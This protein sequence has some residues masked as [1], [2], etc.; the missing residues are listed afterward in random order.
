MQAPDKPKRTLQIVP[1]V[2]VERE[3]RELIESHEGEYKY[4]YPSLDDPLFNTK[5]AERKEFYDTRYVGKR[6]GKLEEEADRICNAEFELAPHQLFV[7]NFLSFQTP[8]NSLL[9]YH[10]LGSGKTCSAISVAEEMRDYL[11]QMG[12]VQRIIVVASP[13]VQENFKLQLFDERKLKLVDGLWNIR[14]C[15]GNKFLK[16]I[17]PMNMRGLSKERVIAQV[18]RIISTAYLFLGYI[19]F[20]NYIGKKA[21]VQGDMSEERRAAIAQAKLRKHFNNRLIVI[22][23][24]H[25][26]RITD[27]NKDKRVALELQKLVDNVENMR[28]LLL[29]ATPMYNSYREIVWLLNLMNKN[30]GRSTIDVK[31]VFTPDGTF[32]TDE[33]GREIGKEL[34]MRKATGYVSFVRGENPYMFPFRIWPDEFAPSHSLKE[35]EYPRTQM[36]GRGILQPMEMLSLYMVDIGDY[37]RTGYDY[38]IERLRAGDFAIAGKTL[39]SFE[40]MEAFGYTMLQRPLEALNIIYPD[41]KLGSSPVDPKTLVG[42]GGL[43]RIMSFKEVANPPSRTDFKYK[44]ET[45]GRIFAPDQ[46]GKYSGKIKNIC[47]SVLGSEGVV[48]IY[49]QY[50][51]GGLVPIAL[52]LEELGFTRAGSTK[53]LFAKPPTD[54]IDAVTYKTAKEMGTGFTPAKYVM[55]TGDKALS[56]DNLADFKILT[57]KDNKDGKNVKVVMISQAGSEGLD[58]SFIRQVHVLEPWYNTNR[59]EQIIG[60]AVR[61]CSHKLLPFSKR[62]VEISLYGTR[63]GVE[64]DEAADLYVYRLAELKALQIGAVS[65]ALK[66]GAVDCIL[67]MGQQGFTVDEMDTVV[68]QE[69][70]NGRTIDYAVGDRPFTAICDYMEKCRYTCKPMV[71]IKEDDVSL[72]TY[73]EAF[74]MMNTDKIT[75][76]IRSLMKERFF[77]RKLDLVKEINATKV[78]PMVQINAALNQ[79]VEDKNEYV[80]DRYDRMGRLINIGDLYLFQPLELNNDHVSV[81]DRSTPL[82]YKRPSLS[83]NLP[84]KT[85]AE[86]K[87]AKP[88]GADRL[89]GEVLIREMTSRFETATSKQ[90]IIRGEEDWYKFCSLA[91]DHLETKG[92]SRGELLVLLSHHIVDELVYEDMMKLLNA[93]P[94]LGEKEDSDFMKMVKSYINSM[95]MQ[96]KGITGILL[97]RAGKRQLVVEDKDGSWKVAE[98]EDYEDLSGEIG[99]K[100]KELLPAPTKMN[101]IMGFM[102]NFKKDYIVFKMKYMKRKRHKGARCD[103]SQKKEAVNI[104]NAIRGE[105]EYA[106][107]TAISRMELCIIEEFWM[108]KYTREKK[109]GKVWFLNPA[110]AV[111]VDI[112]K[113]SF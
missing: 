77:Y 98:A 25:N 102:A 13:N 42:K 103:Q 51:D 44:E 8:Y 41:A 50:I 95:K 84:A 82:D 101:E 28:L 80:V 16:E 65:R 108:R 71:E 2:D 33:S 32:K 24:I 93:I 1:N 20:A 11:K 55:I 53:S 106:Q 47:D 37:Q 91:I 10:G 68:P 30:D 74:I 81:Y 72:D 92:I 15:T 6:P 99:E 36:N 89:E 109:E 104:I 49:S 75:Q 48:L 31:N 40:N 100:G 12:I 87:A 3:D 19:E 85:Q 61:T 110:E 23:E 73:S 105:D 76:R 86:K 107:D 39:P 78:Y 94:L 62:N 29:S 38:I 67:N 18:K 9:L 26:V 57:D 46:I 14:A 22:D 66:E 5:I 112:E 4:L 59:I 56:P 7:R 64:S 34:L 83:F 90:V 35:M 43:E 27:D 63:M 45:F 88:R 70:S 60:R 96:A 69:L 21:T 111:L 52:A 54:L 79:L 97:Q 17:N 113:L 58:F